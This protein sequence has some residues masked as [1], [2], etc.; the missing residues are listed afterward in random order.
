[1]YLRFPRSTSDEAHWPRE[2]PPRNCCVELILSWIYGTCRFS[3]G[4]TCMNYQRLLSGLRDSPV[5]EANRLCYTPRSR[6][7]SLKAPGIPL[8]GIDRKYRFT[9]EVFLPGPELRFYCIRKHSPG[10]PQTRLPFR[11]SKHGQEL[12]RRR[13]AGPPDISALYF[14]LGFMGYGCHGC[15]LSTCHH[16][17]SARLRATPCHHADKTPCVYK[18]GVLML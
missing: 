1:M 6:R 2:T 8:S 5:Q 14:I 10:F 11:S 13:P 16:I 7:T 15:Q 3:H 17:S 9:S 4:H 18:S 12:H